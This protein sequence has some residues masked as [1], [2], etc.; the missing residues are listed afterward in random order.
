VLFLGV[1][2]GFGLILNDF[3]E[4]ASSAFYYNYQKSNIAGGLYYWVLFTLISFAF[5]FAVF[6]LSFK[7]IDLA[8]T[9][10]EKIELAKNNFTIAGLHTVVFLSICLVVSKPLIAWA[11]GLVNFPIYP[12]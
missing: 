9:E 10:N 6:H 7:L 11:N 1:I 5:S 3:S 8:T 4:I 2:F 12:N